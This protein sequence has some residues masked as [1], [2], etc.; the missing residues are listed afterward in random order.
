MASAWTL[1]SCLCLLLATSAASQKC[2]SD[3]C[4]GDQVSLLQTV[5]KVQKSVE[6]ATLA[7]PTSKSSGYV[8]KGSKEE[9]SGVDSIIRN[10]EDDE[11]TWKNN[12]R[13]K[14]TLQSG[15]NL[16]DRDWWG[17]SDPYCKIKLVNKNATKR[18]SPIVRDSTNPTWNFKWETVDWSEGDQVEFDCYDEDLGT[19]AHLGKGTFLPNRNKPFH[20]D[21]ELFRKSHGRG[22]LRVFLEWEDCEG[23]CEV[24]AVTMAKLANNVYSFTNQAG[25]FHMVRAL[26][27]QSVW[28]PGGKD[29]MAIYKKHGSKECA[30]AFSGS[31]DVHDWIVNN[32]AFMANRG[33]CGYEEIH[34]GFAREVRNFFKSREMA[35]FSEIISRLC[36][37]EVYTT[38]HSLGGAAA[39]IV[40]GCASSDG[41][42]SGIGGVP[43]DVK[44]FKVKGLYTIGSPAVSMPA[45]TGTGGECF[46]GQRAFNYD[47]HTF[48]IVAW[49]AQKL[50]YL[51]P[52]VLAVELRES[53]TT[54]SK[55]RVLSKEDYK[56]RTTEAEHRPWKK[57]ETLP[58]KGPSIHDHL[59]S[60][61]ISRLKEIFIK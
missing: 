35:V 58:L 6:H 37:G 56:C 8:S 55:N 34:G 30:L 29:H 59:A 2:Q 21:V 57:G 28:I 61:Y 43:K 40:A 10:I 3:V 50:G 33:M 11:K 60:E 36:Y 31:N 45:M 47:S 52:K 22:H 12:I 16:E 9:A 39:T 51:Q 53:G 24:L 25:N 18:T 27:L 49:V 48:D 26:N 7:A 13:L 5:S 4:K 1:R 38:G 41:G 32:F 46:S 19:D 23:D 17:K 44:S 20:G 42:L 14:V 54:S 15:R